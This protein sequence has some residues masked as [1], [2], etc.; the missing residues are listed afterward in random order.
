MEIDRSEEK[1][2][3]DSN[4]YTKTLQRS[5]L[6]EDLIDRAAIF[7]ISP[8]GFSVYIFVKGNVHEYTCIVSNGKKLIILF[9]NMSQ[10]DL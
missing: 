3:I 5:V 8:S 2:V 10:N 7:T 6:S 1:I 9:V 4:T